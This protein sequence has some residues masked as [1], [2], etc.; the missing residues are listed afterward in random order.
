MRIKVCGL[1]RCED[2]QHAVKLGAW[3]LG[4]IFYARSPRA[5]TPELAAPIVQ[6]VK[7]VKTVGVFVDA[8]VAEI[9]KTVRA[10]G[11]DMVQLH[12]AESAGFCAELVRE[13]P[14]IGLIKALR[15]KNSEDLVGLDDFSTY[16]EAMLLD[17]YVSGVQGG[18][19]VTG[20][21]KLASESAKRCNVILAGGLNADNV[22]AAA[23]TPGIFALDVSSGLEESHGK[24]SHE[25]M[26]LFFAR[27]QSATRSE[28]R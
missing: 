15:P 1:T 9:V 11:I 22:V 3:A 12:G 13:L 18:T 8:G 6:A 14:G 16:C 26:N 23:A 19:G 27:A 7:S 20:D 4:F 17:S 21:W 24:K 2:A 10:T 5:V 25:K 28:T